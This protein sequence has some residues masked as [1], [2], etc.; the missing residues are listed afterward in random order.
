MN[1]TPMETITQDN[2][3]GL[4]LAVE[5]IHK[6]VG[7]QEQRHAAQNGDRQGQQG[8]GQRPEVNAGRLQPPGGHHGDHGP[9]RHGVA[10]RKV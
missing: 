1:M 5:A 2:R 4:L 3:S 10:M 9:E 7:D 6:A 8:G